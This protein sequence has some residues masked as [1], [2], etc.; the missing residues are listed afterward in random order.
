MKYEDAD[1]I[2]D[3]CT[4]PNQRYWHRDKNICLDCLKKSETVRKAVRKQELDDWRATLPTCQRCGKRGANY[5]LSYVFKLSGYCK[6]AVMREH[7]R[8]AASANIIAL[9]GG[10]L[11]VDFST[12]K[13]L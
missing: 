12:W 4:H 6:G 3:N 2:L 5:T 11:L 10:E 7:K 8:N 9:I 13:N 1:A